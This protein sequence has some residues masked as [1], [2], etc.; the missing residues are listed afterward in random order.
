MTLDI[1]LLHEENSKLLQENKRLCPVNN[2][3]F[4]QD[5]KIERQ[6][7]LKDNFIKELQETIKYLQLENGALKRTKIEISKQSCLIYKLESKN[8]ELENRLKILS[9]LRTKRSGMKGSMMSSCSEISLNLSV[10]DDELDKLYNVLMTTQRSNSIPA[11][12]DN[13]QNKKSM[14][15]EMDRTLFSPWWGSKL[16]A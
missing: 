1:K 3:H 15:E 13:G 12:E 8:Q 6:L 14:A 4:I 9:T 2:Q 11:K 7:I 16:K 5:S 10:D